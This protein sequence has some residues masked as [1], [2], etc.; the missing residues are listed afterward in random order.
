MIK[1]ILV[2]LGGSRFMDSVITTATHLA[3]RHDATLYGC[4]IVD[5]TLLDPGESVPV[6]GGG[7]AKE[8]REQRVELARTGAHEAMHRF[9]EQCERMGVTYTSEVLEGDCGEMLRNAWRFQDIG[10]IGLREIFD[11]GVVTQ[12]PEIVV[13][14]INDGVRPLIAVDSKA[15]EMKRILVAFNG[16]FESCKALKQWTLL[17]SNPEVSVRIVTIGDDCTEEDLE[18]ARAYVDDHEVA[19]VETVRL[20]GPGAATILEE[21]DRWGADLVIAGSTGR[22]WI[23]RMVIGDTARE[24][25][26]NSNVALYMLH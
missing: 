16:S 6:G 22:T 19:S 12:D 26:E 5:E 7:A 15:T 20:E 11:Y 18:K 14:L 23:S 10:L 13:R 3:Q 2:V 24:L 8:A 21:S 4:A 1:R 9:E 17:H 25:V